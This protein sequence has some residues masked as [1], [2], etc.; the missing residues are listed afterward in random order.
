MT[1]NSFAESYLG[2]LRAQ[3]GRRLLLVPGARIVIED[4]QGRILLQHRSDVRVWG[5]PAGSAEPGESL[6]QAIVRE[7]REETG[8]EVLQVQP[9]GFANDPAHETRTYPNGDQCQF[10]SMLFW[11]NAY[12]GEPRICDDESLAL[13]WFLPTDLPEMLPN[14]ARSVA[15]FL[16]Y[17]ETRAFQ[18]I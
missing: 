7:V 6:D 12:R 10:F 9:Y 1:Q 2:Q 17:R 14:M 11:S 8:L 18:L 16:R 13:E 5:L 15:A 3:V 4:P